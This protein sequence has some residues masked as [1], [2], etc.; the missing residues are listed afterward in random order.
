MTVEVATR[1]HDFAPRTLVV[2]AG[3]SV[4]VVY[5]NQEDGTEH[6]IA[7]YTRPGGNL[8]VHSENIVGPNGV[9]EVVLPP[10]GAGTYFLQCDIHPFMTAMLVVRT[11]NST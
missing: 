11:P 1:N 6:N 8:I 3:V 2:P 7:F 4:R 5:R 9:S 10:L